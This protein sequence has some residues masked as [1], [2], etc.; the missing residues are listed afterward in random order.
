MP[1]LYR[2]RINEIVRRHN[3]ARQILGIPNTPLMLSCLGQHESQ[4]TL[5]V[6]YA[7][8]NPEGRWPVSSRRTLMTIQAPNHDE[9]VFS[10]FIVGPSVL[11]ALMTTIEGADCWIDHIVALTNEVLEGVWTVRRQGSRFILTS[12]EGDTL[13][14]NQSHLTLRNFAVLGGSSS[15]L[16]HNPRPGRVLRAIPN[17]TLN[18]P[19][20]VSPRALVDA[21]RVS[22]SLEGAFDPDMNFTAE[23]TD[24]SN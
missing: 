24:A 17:P 13:P 12:V 21:E 7:Y 16:V 1:N 6:Y 23:E 5:A 2:V 22:P 19:T 18:L 4:D 11:S 9:Q 10:L 15:R 20:T 14:M 8:D 3:C